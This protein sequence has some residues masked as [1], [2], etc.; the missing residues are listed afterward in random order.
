MKYNETEIKEDILSFL[1]ENREASPQSVTKIRL[2]A[3]LGDKK[4]DMRTVKIC[5]EELLK[6]GLIKKQSD[7]GNYKIDDKG[8]EHMEES[9]EN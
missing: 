3:N 8:I 1:Y 6:K 5:L 9:I 4:G 7:R 2:A